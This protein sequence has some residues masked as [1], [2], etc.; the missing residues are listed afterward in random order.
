[1]LYPCCTN[2][3]VVEYIGAIE[4]WVVVLGFPQTEVMK[5]LV[6]DVMILDEAEEAYTSLTLGAQK[7]VD[8][9]Y[10]LNQLC[11]GFA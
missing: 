5:N 11:L 8:L 10:L 7:W 2:D 4:C 1:M 9:T 3:E 6:D